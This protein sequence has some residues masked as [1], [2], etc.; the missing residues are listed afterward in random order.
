MLILGIDTSFYHLTLSL[1]EDD[2]LIKDKVR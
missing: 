2:V 1:I